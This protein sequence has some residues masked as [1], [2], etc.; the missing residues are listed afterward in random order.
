MG[1]IMGQLS[2]FCSRDEE[3][4]DTSKI[5]IAT[6]QLEASSVEQEATITSLSPMAKDKNPNKTLSE[7]ESAEVRRLFT[8][9]TQRACG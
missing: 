9:Q 1:N 5:S 4:A 8:H 6:D 3:K 2:V 7:E